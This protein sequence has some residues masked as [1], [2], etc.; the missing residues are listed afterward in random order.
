MGKR[1]ARSPELGQ[2]KLRRFRNENGKN[3]KNQAL[4]QREAPR[5][6]QLSCASGRKWRRRVSSLPAVPCTWLPTFRRRL[7]V[8][9][10]LSHRGGLHF[11]DRLK[12]VRTLRGVGINE[13]EQTGTVSLGSDF[14]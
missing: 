8:V 10:V 4:W 13:V 5:S 7:Q 2:R 14:V 3:G 11:E 6:S 12:E 1:K 9:R